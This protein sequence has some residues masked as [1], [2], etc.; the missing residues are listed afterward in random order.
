MAKKSAELGKG[1][2]ALLGDIDADMN[3]NTELIRSDVFQGV[4]HVSLNDIEVNPFQPRADFDQ[5]ALDDLAESIKVHGVIQP[6]TV[7]RLKSGKFQLIAGERR[8]RASRLAG[9]VSIPAFVREAND[10]EMLEIAL[11]ENIQREDLNPIE[12]A[13]NY[14]RL[15][16][17]CDLTQEAL[18]T[19]LGKSRSGITNALRLLKLPAII[20]SG[21]KKGDLSMGHSRALLSLESEE[22][23]IKLFKRILSDGLSVRQVEELVKS[24]KSSD[25]P[26]TKKK[27]NDISAEWLNH[28]NMLSNAYGRRINI[29]SKGK[30]SGE[31]VIPFKSGADLDKL[32]Q[33]LEE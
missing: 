2:R 7:R 21:L 22:D 20:Q 13:L 9:L 14:R 27:R 1:I 15:L 25:N 11:I 12:I 23:Q 6:I 29:R 30:G 4:S 18:A 5:N 28:C 26:V 17:E 3:R 33:Q 16:E 19:R 10:Q 31:I 8:T 32:I 24:S